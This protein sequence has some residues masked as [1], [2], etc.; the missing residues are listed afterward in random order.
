MKNTFYKAERLGLTL[1]LATGLGGFAALAH[2][3]QYVPRSEIQQAQGE[4]RNE[5]YY[6]G[7]ING[8]VGFRMHRAIRRYQRANNLA[9]NGR[10]DPQ[11]IQSL[12]VTT[13]S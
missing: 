4:L 10:L 13:G 8:H 1:F 2:G 6:H 3:Y 5:G 7:R 12:G 9:V 11:T